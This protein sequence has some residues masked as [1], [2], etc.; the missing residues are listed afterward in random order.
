MP[1]KLFCGIYHV[2]LDICRKLLQQK[3]SKV[4][5]RNTNITV[6]R[7]ILNL[8]MLGNFACF[9][10]FCLF[11]SKASF[12]NSSFRNTIR[13]SSSLDPDQARHFVGPDLVPNSLLMF[14]TYQQVAL[15]GKELTNN[16]Y[17]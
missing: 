15:V 10:V 3:N 1:N 5:A 14:Q 8:C 6:F 13:V 12:L 17:F 16:I 4:N 2:K 11:L 9:F 7:E